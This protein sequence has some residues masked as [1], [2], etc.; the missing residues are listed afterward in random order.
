MLK[1]KQCL[2]LWNELNEIYF[3]LCYIFYKER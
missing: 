2:A 1:R 3:I